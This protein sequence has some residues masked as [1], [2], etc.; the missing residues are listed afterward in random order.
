M[1]TAPEKPAEPGIKHAQR[2]ARIWVIVA[3]A[4]IVLTLVA[5]AFLYGKT[6]ASETMA[7][8]RG[9]VIVEQ[10]S[11]LGTT[12]RLAGGKV[13]NDPQ[14]KDA[15]ARKARGEPAVPAAADVI[16]SHDG[17]PGVGID[18]ARQVD[19]CYVEVGLTDGVVTRYGP[20]CGKD[21][22]PGKTGPTGVSGTPG[23][24][25][26]D[27]STGAQGVGV[28]DVRANGC[29]VD[30]V[31]TDGSTRTVGPFCGPP[32]PEYTLNKPDGSAMHC[33]RG[34]GGSDTAPVY[35]CEQTRPP[36]TTQPP[37]ATQTETQ[38][39]TATVT[40]TTTAPGGLLPTG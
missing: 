25:G 20:F 19:R 26:E 38:T 39:E 28:A 31:L 15:C 21:G 1:T 5:G 11:L 6:T 8:E 7:N 32:V 27:G 16:E 12:C 23:I 9:Y 34:S 2:R 35:N 36:T 13:N 29:N 17:K 22:K 4:C 14:A 37:P 33:V 3:G 40:E 30:V 18:Y 24:D 10:D